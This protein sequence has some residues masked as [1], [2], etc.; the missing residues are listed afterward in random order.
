MKRMGMAPTLVLCSRNARPQKGLVR[1]PH[2]DQHGYPPQGEKAS[3]LGRIDL[4]IDRRWP[5]DAHN[6]GQSGYSPEGEV[7]K[8]RC[9]AGDLSWEVSLTHVQEFMTMLKIRHV[10]I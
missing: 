4:L 9:C 6:E 1:R 10:G 7:E 8:V 2:L 5:S 3:K